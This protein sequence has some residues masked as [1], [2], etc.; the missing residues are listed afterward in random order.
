[1]IT[2]DSS[3][4]EIAIEDIPQALMDEVTGA[5]QHFAVPLLKAPPSGERWESFPI[6]GTGTLVHI[7]GTHFILTASHV[8]REIKKSSDVFL[9]LKNTPSRYVISTNSL[10]AQ[11]LAR[12]GPEAW[13]P[14]LALVKIPHMHVSTIAASKSFLN[15][16]GH[17]AE[18]AA[19]PCPVEKGFWVVFGLV[20]E[21]SHLEVDESAK[22]ITAQSV[23]RGLFSVIDETHERE[24]CDFLDISVNTKLDGVPRSFGGVSGGGLWRIDLQKSRSTGA[25]TWD[26]KRHF[27]GVAFWQSDEEN[28]HKVV[29]CHGPRSIFDKAWQAWGLGAT[30]Q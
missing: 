15:L 22:T 27:R 16:S 23:G 14:D 2:G 10:S 19:K 8:W 28:G 3:I 12:T 21:F 6:G 9:L 5:L 7:D 26:G 18:F 11:E 1:M 13:G 29:R 4:F 17:R 30:Q 20:H 24:G 25:I